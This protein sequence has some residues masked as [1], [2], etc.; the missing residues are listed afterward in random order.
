[1]NTNKV[2]VS[3]WYRA[4]GPSV[5][6][7][8]KMTPVL[9]GMGSTS[10]VEGLFSH[11]GEV[12]TPSRS[13]MTGPRAEAVIIE[14]IVYRMNRRAAPTPFEVPRW[15]SFAAIVAEGADGDDV[16]EGEE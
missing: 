16:E 6:D 11:A 4:I 12:V 8:V 5:P 9:G 1:M 10:A 3:A 2:V 7:I 15:P 14:R 13:R